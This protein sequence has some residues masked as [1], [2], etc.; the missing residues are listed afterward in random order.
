MAMEPEFLELMTQTITRRPS[1]SIDSYGARTYGPP[2]QH[3]CHIDGATT[4]VIGPD[5]NTITADGQLWMPH[6]PDAATS[7]TITLPG[8]TKPRKIITVK[9]VYDE[10]GPHHTKLYYGGMI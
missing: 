2:S 5:G 6:A 4:E 1:A 10:T 7:D 8:E 9:T 3:P